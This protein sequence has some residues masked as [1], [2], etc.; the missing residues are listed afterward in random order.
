MRLAQCPLCRLQRPIQPRHTA[1]LTDFGFSKSMIS[2]TIARKPR[3]DDDGKLRFP[4]AVDRISRCSGTLRNWFFWKG[5]EALSK[6]FKRWLSQK[7]L[8][9]KLT[10]PEISSIEPLSKVFDFIYGHR[11]LALSTFLRTAAISIIALLV[12]LVVFYSSDRPIPAAFGAQQ[13]SSLWA[14]GKAYPV[15]FTLAVTL[16]IFF[17]Y[18]SVTKSRFLIDKIVTFQKKYAVIVFIVVDLILT[19]IILFAYLIVAYSYEPAF[20]PGRLSVEEFWR[21]RAAWEIWSD[22]F[23]LTTFLTLLLT[24]VYSISLTLL[25]FFNFLGK[26]AYLRWLVP[27]TLS[28]VRWVLPVETSPVRSIGVVAGAFTFIFVAA[29]RAFQ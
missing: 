3:I 28:I 15:E 13:I 16:N 11:Y 20:A 12:A 27:E 8:L 2:V 25:M 21:M 7:I 22:A 17:D 24:T 18:L 23:F 26:R 29:F 1:G 4:T 9:G 5:D 19:T 14:V 6:D 10:V